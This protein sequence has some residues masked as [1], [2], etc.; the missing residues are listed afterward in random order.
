MNKSE[1]VSQ[2]N[3]QMPALHRDEIEA[4]VDQVIANIE[5]S[6]HEGEPVLISRFGTFQVVDRAATRRR[7]PR[8]GKLIDIPAKKKVAFRPSDILMAKVNDE[9]QL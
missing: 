8:D 5:R 4:V 7:N 2:C 9:H 3:R 6:L 1:L